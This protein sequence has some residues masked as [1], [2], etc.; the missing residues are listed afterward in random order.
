MAY[1]ANVSDKQQ[2]DIERAADDSAIR[3]PWFDGKAQQ[4]GEVKSVP[5][6]DLQAQGNTGSSGARGVAL[7][8]G[9][10][11]VIGSHNDHPS[12]FETPGKA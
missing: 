2:T 5:A 8:S 4:T 1:I 12:R 10:K 7:T 3:F 11:L 9:S 6:Y